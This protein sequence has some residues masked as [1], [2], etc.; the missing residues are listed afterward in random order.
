MIIIPNARGVSGQTVST[1]DYVLVPPRGSVAKHM[2]R[3]A[4]AMGANPF[5]RAVIQQ[6]YAMF[7][8]AG[9][10]EVCDTFGFSARSETD[11]LINWIEGG[12]TPVAVGAVWSNDVGW[13]TDGVDQM[14]DLGVGGGGKFQ[15]ESAHLAVFTPNPPPINNAIAIG[16]VGGTLTNHIMPITAGTNSGARSNS[17]TTIT[18]SNPGRDYGSIIINRRSA[19]TMRMLGNGQL[20]LEQENT[21]TGMSPANF[22]LGRSQAVYHQSVIAGWSIGGGLS[23]AQEQALSAIMGLLGARFAPKP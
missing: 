7:R 18:A 21:A 4:S 2:D 20:L 6:A 14:V 10:H 13:T 1:S 16:Q 8:A 3:Y 5:F 23:D 19:S 11:S 12:P 15:L 17:S 9:L 22:A